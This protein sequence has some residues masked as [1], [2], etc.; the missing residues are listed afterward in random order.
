MNLV[1]RGTKVKFGSYRVGIVDGNDIETTEDFENINYFVCPIEYT[2][3]KFWSDDYI[4]LLRNEFEI[5]D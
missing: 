3:K 1:K 4:P 2:Y 5:I